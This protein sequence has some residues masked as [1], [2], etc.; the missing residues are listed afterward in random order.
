MRADKNQQLTAADVVNGYSEDALLGILKNYGELKYTK[1]IT[2]DIAEARK[3]KKIETTFELV[4]ILKQKIP[5]RF[6]NKD[7]SK[8]FQAIR[9]EVNG[10]LENLKRVLEAS[11]GLLET[12]GRIV[13]VSYHSLE[14]RIVKNVL[15]SAPEL[16][17]LTKKPVEAGEAETER[18]TRA[19]SAR[20]R[21]A[22]KK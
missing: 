20:L 16:R 10:E 22:E 2:R 21:A 9:I 11:A 7:L 13:A 5:P 17:V 12:G 18:N 3:V 4:E 6:L 19:R 15:R 14:D 8:V 1:Q